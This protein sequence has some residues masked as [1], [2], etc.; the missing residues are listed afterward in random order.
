[1]NRDIR[2]IREAEFRSQ[3][4]GV[5]RAGY[6]NDV[7][8]LYG[9]NNRIPQI[10]FYSFIL[11]LFYLPV[12]VVFFKAFLHRN[13]LGQF[14]EFLSSQVFLNTLSFSVKEACISSLGSL[15]LAFP[16]AYFFGRYEFPG[17]KLL[18]SIMILPFMFPGILVVLG[19]I[20]FYG[21]NGLLN[22]FL[23]W[24]T[25]DG[26]LQFQSLYGFW[27]I[28]LAHIFY[29]FSFCLRLLSE[30]WE[31]IDPR[32]REASKV[33]GAGVFATLRRITIPLLLPTIS[34]LFALVFLYSFLSFTIVLVLGG[35]LYKTFEVLIYIEYNHKLNFDRASMIAAVQIVLLAGVLF[36]QNIFNRKNKRQVNIYR[37]LPKLSMKKRPLATL[38]FQNYLLLVTVFFAGPLITILSRSLNSSGLAGTQLTLDNYRLLFQEG[39][40]FTV[41]T[42]FPELIGVS[43]LIALTVAV[44]SISLAY[45][46]AGYRRNNSW[47]WLDIWFQLPLGI[48]FLTFAF[49]IAVLGKPLPNW[50]L[51]VWAQ[52]FLV[53]PLVY[54]ILSSARHEFGDSLMEAAATLGA[55][56]ITIF[57]TVEFPMMKKAVGTAFA[58]AIALSLGDLTS[59]LVLGNGKV[60]TISL[61]VYQLIGHYRFAQATALG[62][63]YILLS[64]LLFIV[65]E[66]R[67]SKNRSQ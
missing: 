63:I 15:L 64:L 42:N 32:L 5:R 36:L 17:K 3:E 7:F 31:R 46:T 4:S 47:G 41:G 60:N 33:L 58:Y 22:H 13:A 11:S 45:I 20:V 59:V 27:G 55:N 2:S 25:P 38:V 44:I 37:E 12:L 29:N 48:S 43:L 40:K 16:G 56:P 8:T 50:V 30:S 65:I 57:R 19:M 18:R 54:S 26:G 66:Q 35:Y 24:L 52:V 51:I 34:Y 9:R 28:I 10:I 14:G 21:R 62:S 23:S 61:A 67:S 49:G 6:F 1:M 53:F 39:F